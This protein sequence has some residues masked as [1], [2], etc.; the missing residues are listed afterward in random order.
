MKMQQNIKTVEDCEKFISS[1]L[2][3]PKTI[4]LDIPF[5]S[6]EENFKYNEQINKYRNA[7]GCETGSVFLTI[8]SVVC[9]IGIVSNFSFFEFS[10]LHKVLFSVVFI[11]IFSIIGKL[12]GLFIA[13]IKLY[14]LLKNLKKKIAQ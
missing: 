5:L 14:R 9:I 11:F 12:V 2:I 8:A 6:Q 7:C 4:K 3:Y 13:K 10:F 1:P